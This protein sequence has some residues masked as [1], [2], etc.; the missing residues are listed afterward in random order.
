MALICLIIASNVARCILLQTLGYDAK[1]I[2]PK[3]LDECWRWLRAAQDVQSH[4]EVDEELNDQCPREIPKR[5]QRPTSIEVLDLGR[6]F[7]VRNSQTQ[8]YRRNGSS[9]AQWMGA[10]VGR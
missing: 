7:G 10:S 5:W 6:N 1:A 3:N 4:L 2:R 9:D 8:M